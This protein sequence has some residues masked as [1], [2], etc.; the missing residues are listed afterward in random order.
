MRCIDIGTH[1]IGPG[2]PCFVVAE[3]GVNHNG[4]RETA[5][6]LIDAAVEAGADAVK[7][8]T[9]TAEKVI[10]PHAPKAAYQTQTTSADESQL[11]M[12]R[13]LELS[14]GIH[15]DLKSHC[16][17][18]GILFLSTPFDEDSADLLQQMDVPMFKVPSGEITNPDFVRHIAQKGKPLL[19]STGMACLGEVETAVRTIEKAGNENIVLLHCV[20]NYPADPSDVNLRAMALMSAAF[21]VPVGYSDHT[22]GIAVALAAVAL[23]ACVIEKHFTLDCSMPGPDHRASVEPEE[24]AA[25]VRGIRTVEKS[26]GSGRKEPA[27]SEAGI[28]EVARRSLVAARDIPA[29]TCLSAEMIAVKRPGTGLAPCFK[30]ILVG[31]RAGRDVS[32]GTLLS[33]EMLA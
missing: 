31:R 28:A 22:L 12:A 14:A 6:Q 26:L 27:A 33:W 16:K 23:G 3:A 13:R 7:F 1:R 18:K 9:F 21:G 2:N 11:D 10:S 24:L 30:P 17:D 4:N 25:M 29:G 8:Q 32:A 19:V 5:L 20:S 15:W